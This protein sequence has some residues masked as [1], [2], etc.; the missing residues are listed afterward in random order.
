MVL[1]TD[2]CRLLVFLLLPNRT[3]PDKAKIH[4]TSFP[5]ARSWQ[6]VG[7]EAPA[8][9]HWLW[10]DLSLS[11]PRTLCIYVIRITKKVTD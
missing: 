9:K 10:L 8:S 4:Y 3:L 7:N 6:Q 11:T 5:A 1:A 2:V